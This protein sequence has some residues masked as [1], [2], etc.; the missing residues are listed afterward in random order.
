M[1]TIDGGAAVTFALLSLALL[2]LALP[3]R[4]RVTAW[5]W[6]APFLLSAAAGV[7]SGVLRP[8]ALAA[9][10]LLGVACIGARSGALP[11]SARA[12]AGAVVVALYVAFM[13]HVAPGFDN[14][15]V[16]DRV[17]LGPGA[18]PFTKQLNYDK[19][20]AGLFLLGI[21][22]RPPGTPRDWRATARGCAARLPAVV[23]V[24][25]L[26]S[27]ATGYVRWDPKASGW[28]PVWAWST[29]LFTVVAEEAFFRGLIQTSLQR[30]LG[31][32]GR[33]ALGAWVAASLL[34]GLAHLA[35]GPLYVALATVA[36]LGYGWVFVRTGSIRAAVLCHF[37]V[38]A[39]HFTLFTYPALASAV[40]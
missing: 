21:W 1:T 32:R 40:R 35:G 19:G 30:W 34:F 17:V 18:L 25:L 36:G 5:A 3:G 13:L 6:L 2:S 10:L 26:L 27:L 7:A 33:A 4:R 38:N 12:L 39:L 9:M 8:P 24:V 20:V 37:A 11:L 16:M 22:Y 23:L 29:L 28:F 14:P 15:V 31:A